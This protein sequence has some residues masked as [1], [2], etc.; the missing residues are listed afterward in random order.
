MSA[1][2]C[3]VKLI[4]L[5]SRPDLNELFGSVEKIVIVENVQRYTVLVLLSCEIVN[6]QFKNVI[7]INPHVQCE[8]QSN[9]EELIEL[10]QMKEDSISSTKGFDFHLNAGQLQS[11]WSSPLVITYSCAIR[12]APSKYNDGRYIPLSKLNLQ[13]RV[14]SVQDNDEFIEINDIAFDIHSIETVHLLKGNVLFRRCSFKSLDCG[15]SSICNSVFENCTFDNL[16]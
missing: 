8:F 9:G 14:K 11:I 4:G 1:V 10:S 15:V 2:G 6:V 12:G 7:L 16:F 13:L 5:I 3:I